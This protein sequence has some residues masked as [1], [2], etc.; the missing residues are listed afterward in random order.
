[1]KLADDLWPSQT[2]ASLVEAA[3]ANLAINARDAM[4]EGGRLTIETGNKRLDERYAAENSDAAR[5]CSTSSS[6][7]RTGSCPAAPWP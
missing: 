4:P 3:L 5:P 7:S 1:M 2:D 6:R